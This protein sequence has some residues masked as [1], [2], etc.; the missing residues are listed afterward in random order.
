MDRF[1]VG[2]FDDC[3]LVELRSILCVLKKRLKKASLR[4]RL[5]D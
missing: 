3:V 1:V 2:A 4:A 5:D